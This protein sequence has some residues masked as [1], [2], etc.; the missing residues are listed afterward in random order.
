MSNFKKNHESASVGP[1]QVALD[2]AVRRATSVR[3]M[4]KP[5]S[6]NIR[7][8]LGIYANVFAVLVALGL[9]NGVLRHETGRALASFDGAVRQAS[10]GVIHAVSTDHGVAPAVAP[11]PAQ[12]DP[13]SPPATESAATEFPEQYL[14]DGLSEEVSAPPVTLVPEPPESPAPGLPAAAAPGTSPDNVPD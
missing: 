6:R 8:V 1:D 3:R 4:A 10:T 7:R 9:P 11:E 5:R 12:P 2:E 14:M 13:A